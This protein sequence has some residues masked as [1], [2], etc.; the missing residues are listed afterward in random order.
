MNT[1]EDISEVVN[2]AD[3][4][5]FQKHV[6]KTKEERMASIMAG[7][8]GR[9]FGSKKGRRDDKP[10]TNK[11][12]LSSKPFMLV[13]YSKNIQKKKHMTTREKQKAKRKHTLHQKNQL[14]YKH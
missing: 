2:P 5:G 11:E 10:S 1:S 9:E 13:R 7:R 3:L 6:R 12:K 14:K 4:E 8:E